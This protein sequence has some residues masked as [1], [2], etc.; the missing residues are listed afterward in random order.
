MSIPVDNTMIELSGFEHEEKREM[1]CC[2]CGDAL[3]PDIIFGGLRFF[4]CRPCDQWAVP[5]PPIRH[6]SA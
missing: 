1:L 3:E 4:V 6:R 2:R 5:H